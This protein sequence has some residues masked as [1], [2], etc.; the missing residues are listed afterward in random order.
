MDLSGGLGSALK[1]S[2]KRI[3]NSATRHRTLQHKPALERELVDSEI[4]T[5]ASFRAAVEASPRLIV[6]KNP[7]LHSH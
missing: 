6:Y 4:S 1:I 2:P 7:V 3:R 5:N